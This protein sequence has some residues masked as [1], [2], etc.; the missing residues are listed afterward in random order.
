MGETERGCVG[1]LDL[2]NYK[3][4]LGG[5]LCDVCEGEN[6][7]KSP[8]PEDRLECH[9]C[10][11]AFDGDCLENPTNM[12]I[13]PVYNQNQVCVSK[14]TSENG[15][16]RGCSE[17][18]KCESDSVYDCELCTSNSCNKGKL[19][20]LRGVGKPGAWQSLPLTCLSCEGDDCSTTSKSNTCQ[21]NPEQNCVTVFS[22]D[23]VISRGCADDVYESHIDHCR[24]NPGS[25]H[26]C[27]SN[28][29]NALSSRSA[30]TTCVT[31]ESSIDPNCAENVDKI[32]TTR[33]CNGKC[34]TALHPLSHEENSA[35][36]VVR[37]CLDDKEE[38]DALVCN[39]EKCKV[40]EGDSCN[41]DILDV[42]SLSCHHC[43]GDCEFYE[44][45]KCSFYKED[46]QCFMRFDNTSSVVE[47]GCAS[48]FTTQELSSNARDLFLCSGNN[49]NDYPALPQVNYCV[50]C[51]SKNDKDCA[52]HPDKVSTAVGCGTPPHTSCFSRV[53]DGKFFFLNIG[54]K[55]YYVYL[56]L[57]QRRPY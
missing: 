22:G 27:K 32:T 26:E 42:I 51:N 41:K 38:S 36:E 18:V 21:N 12:A 57:T 3:N 16:V 52:T 40:C 46:D 5:L 14:V 56:S 44:S 15:I 23:N 35:Y 19:L 28:E 13:C 24:N 11:S 48:K 33:Q 50:S 17:Q 25:C 29:C 54:C 1:E 34:M 4:C 31:C 8:Y 47:M 37:S 10:N 2:E 20:N 49:C 39:D 30:L 45:K 55:L 43:S 6:C 53:N 9:V 7:N